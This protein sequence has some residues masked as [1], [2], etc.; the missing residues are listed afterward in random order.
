VHA[1]DEAQLQDTIAKVERLAAALEVADATCT[2]LPHSDSGAAAAAAAAAAATSRD[3]P[4]LSFVSGGGPSSTAEQTITIFGA[5]LVAGPCVEYL[6]RDP[7]RHV[8]LVSG[9]AGEAEAMAARLGGGR[10]ISCRTIDVGGDDAQVD[11]LVADTDVVVSL[12]PAPMHPGLA[13]KCIDQGKHMVTAS[14]ISDEMRAL[15]AA[16]KAA[17]VIVMNEVGVDP[18]MDHMSAMKVIDEVRDEG[19]RITSFS[20]LCGGLP[21]PEAANNPLGYKF[22][23]GR[24]PRSLPRP[25]APRYPRSRALPPLFPIACGPAAGAPRVSLAPPRMRRATCW[26]AR[27]SK[28]LAKGFCGLSRR[29]PRLGRR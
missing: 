6:T 17:G 15:D 12:L 25:A 8:V 9:L 26:T 5:G 24:R 27:S 29:R 14:Y 21:A 7:N 16:A 2:V 23:W 10:N 28:P 19:G 3:P 4:A 18:G 11:A 20:S 13:R 1:P 22:R